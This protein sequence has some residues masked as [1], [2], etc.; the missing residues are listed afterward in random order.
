MNNQDIIFGTR[1]VLE[2]IKSGK[3]IEKLFIQKNLSKEIFNEIKNI[4][5]NRNIN[6]SFVPKEKLNRITKKN[7]QGVICYISPIIYQPPNEIIQRCYESGKDPIILILD[8]ITDTRN[9]GAI[10]RV[11]EASGVD[12]III[13][14]KESALITSE[15]VKSSAGAINYVPICKV[16]SLKNIIQEL[17][18]S[19][20]KIIAC[21]EKSEKDIYSFENEVSWQEIQRDDEAFFEFLREVMTVLSSDKT[22]AANPFCSHCD[23]LKR[24]QVDFDNIKNRIAS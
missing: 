18:D 7:H 12:A 16:K 24:S 21:T 2:A 5:K 17:K 22:P 23:Y 19:G 15:A 11:A 4:L 9:F 13:P 8:R 3:S 10:S 20:L 6:I 1:P 14:E